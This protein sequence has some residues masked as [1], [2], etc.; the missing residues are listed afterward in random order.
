MEIGKDI[1]KYDALDTGMFLC[2]PALF[3]DLDLAS[4]DGDCSLSDG[5]RRLARSR[6]LGAIEIDA[7][8]HDLDTPEALAHANEESLEYAA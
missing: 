7:P 8:W 3:D 1:A 2:T 6:R 5:M 4:K